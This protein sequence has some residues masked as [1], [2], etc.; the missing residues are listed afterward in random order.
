MASY[1]RMVIMSMSEE[2]IKRVL[3]EERDS[4]SDY[5]AFMMVEELKRRK[6][7]AESGEELSI[8]EGESDLQDEQDEEG[9]LPEDYE[10]VENIEDIED[11]EELEQ[12]DLDES[13]SDEQRA[14]IKRQR[15]IEELE[16]IKEDRKKTLILACV[17]TVVTALAIVGFMV[18]LAVSGQL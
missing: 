6:E 14:E 15:Q 1:S 9:E 10:F 11:V 3:T 16:K 2:D 12:E 18:Y 13:L 7:L 8:T 5:A 17:G 4:I